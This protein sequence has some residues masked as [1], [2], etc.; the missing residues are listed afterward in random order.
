MGLLCFFSLSCDFKNPL[1]FEMPTWF[2]DLQ[3]PL[4]QKKYSLEGMVNNTQIFSTPDSIGMQLMF[5]GALPDTSIGSDIL[6]VELNQNIQYTQ[7]ATTGP[8]LSFALDTTIN[9]SIPIVPGGQLTNSSD[10]V[11]SVPPTTNQTVNQSVWNT[12]AS[13]IDT[14]IQ[15]TINLPQIPSSQLPIIIQSVN[16]LVIQSDNGANVSD[17]VSTVTND[18][19][20][21]NVT[22]P[23]VALV[24]DIASPPKSL[25]NHTQST[26]AKDA[27]F[28]PETTSLS[29][30]SLGSAIRM[31]IGF[32]IANTSDATVT[33]NAGDSIRV[34]VALRMRIAGVDSAIVQVNQST[35]PFS[36]PKI[37]FPTDIEIFGGKLKSPS[38]FEVNEVNVKSVSSTYPFNVDFDMNFKNFLPPSGKDSIKIDTV[39]KKG[40]TVTKVY[41]MDGYTFTNPS[42]N[43]EALSELTL[44]VSAVLP[45]QTAKIPLDGSN[46]GG[47]SLDVA[48][49]KL[50]FESLEANIIQEFPPT[51]FSIAGMP[52]GFS[53]MEFVNTQLEIE[54]K[55]GIRLPVVLDFDMVGINQSGDSMKVKA[56]STLASPTISGDTTKTIVRLSSEGT[57]TLKYKSPAS[58]AYFDSTNVPPKTGESTIVDLMSSNPAVFNVNSRARIDGRGTLDAN[59]FIGGKYRMLAPFEVI[60]APMTFI[61]VTNTAVQEMNHTNRNRIRSTLQAASL[62]LTVENKIPSG[63]ELA[64]LMSNS[65]YFP[66]DTTVAALSAFKDSMVVKLS[67]ASSDSVFVVS[68]CDSLNPANGNYYIFDVMDDFTD[69]VNGMAYVVKTTGSGMDTV[70]SYV[71]TLL[72]IPLPDP[73]SFYPATNSGVHA[74]QVKE[75]GVATYSSPIPTSTIRLMTNPGQPFMA[76]RFHLKGS[77]GK[78]VYMSTADYID[79]NSNITFNLSSTG[80]TSGAPNEIVVKYPNGGQTLNKDNPLT[81]KWKTFGTVDQV[82]VAYSAGTNPD[83]TKDEGWTNIQTE[84]TNVDSLVWTPSATTGINSMASSLRD[85]VRIR[86]QSTDGKTVDMSGW[87][88]TISHGGSEKSERQIVTT[89]QWGKKNTF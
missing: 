49:K 80:M 87:Y 28:G 1:A 78:K 3:F 76:P 5:E 24:T 52:L 64:M 41:K 6:E 79:I 47:V 57:T 50:H 9:L 4:V 25:A 26:L 58:V 40:V 73:V 32:G 11:F 72:K 21:T 22:N 7:P 55:N 35:L 19:V 14:T 30:D 84:L 65:G 60:M 83:M 15:V 12:I 20:P 17:I 56:L 8:T 53:G 69:C 43:D 75:P 66:L 85:S 68:Q 63:G 36:I 70:V 39:L 10:I 71:D 16:G 18:G 27:N 86:I 81:I 88:F 89:N 46:I 34:D 33:I 54:M 29:Q 82:N 59:M 61:S 31:D 74:G 42:G 67:W 2:F 23:T 77:D 37:S 44:D 45:A 48:L 38:T 51:T 13:A 62:D